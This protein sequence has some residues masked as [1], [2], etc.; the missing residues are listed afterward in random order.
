MSVLPNDLVAYGSANMPAADGSTLGGVV[1]FS[2]TKKIAHARSLPSDCQNS[3]NRM[4]ESQIGYRNVC[5][6]LPFIAVVSVAQ[7]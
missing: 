5:K 7:E 2:V 4:R 6:H 3:R 1:D